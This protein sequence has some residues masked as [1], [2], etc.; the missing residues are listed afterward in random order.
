MWS[1]ATMNDLN[2]KLREAFPEE[3]VP[4]R[5]FDLTYV[6]D[7]DR[8]DASL[9]LGVKWPRVD[10]EFWFEHWP[11]YYAFSPEAFRY[12][13][14]SMLEVTA[15]NNIRYDQLFNCIVNSLNTSGDVSIFPEFIVS[16]FVLLRK[17]QSI[18]VDYWSTIIDWSNSGLDSVDIDRIKLT[19]LS[20]LELHS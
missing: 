5:L 19:I 16:R 1:H 9:L 11:S 6:P 18:C 14:P 20:I 12:Y 10:E 4:L 7:S 17:E 13:L 8:S 2:E 15:L 3:P